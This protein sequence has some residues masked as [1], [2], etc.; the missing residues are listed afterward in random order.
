MVA[1]KQTDW[2]D[3]L[4]QSFHGQA[5]ESFLYPPSRRRAWVSRQI[6]ENCA[7]PDIPVLR[8]KWDSADTLA[9]EA[10]R[11]EILAGFYAKTLSQSLRQSR[12]TD[13]PAL[14]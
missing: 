14:I 2:R 10:H 1:T 8:Y 3:A 7:A 12:Q 6:L 13:I 5:D 9:T 11:Q 4:I